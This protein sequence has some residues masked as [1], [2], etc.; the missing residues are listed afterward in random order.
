MDRI[1][2]AL[3][4]LDIASYKINYETRETAE[5]YFVKRNLDLT[6]ANTTTDIVVTVYNDFEKDGV[7]QRGAS[8]FFVFPDT[9]DEEI[10][11]S[12]AK[13]Y[14]QASYVSNPYFDM[15]QGNGVVI[16]TAGEIDLMDKAVAMAEALY[17]ADV[18][19][20]AYIN[21]AEIYAI[22]KNIRIVNS[23]GVD[24][25]FVQYSAEGEFVVQSKENNNDVELFKQFFYDDF[26]TEALAKKCEDSL[27]SVKD[28]AFAL[29]ADNKLP[30]YP[31]ILCDNTVGELLNFYV[32]KTNASLIHPGYSDYRPGKEV[33]PEAEGEKID[34]ELVP[35]RIVDSDGIELKN[36]TILKDGIVKNIHG[37]VQYSY[38][39]GEKCNGTFGKF[40]CNN[41]TVEAKDML[42]EPYIM[43]KSFSD[44]QMDPMDGYFGGEFRL[45]Y[46]FDGNATRILT[47]GTVSGN[48]YAAQ[49]NIVFSKER[50]EDA[51]YDIPRL[52][53][54]VMKQN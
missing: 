29:R 34:I 39:L 7:K 24:Y 5:L 47:G 27:K 50:Y 54:I 22:R 16:K 14:R 10:I 42:K 3:K 36:M 18:N 1:I 12:A 30:D 41:G 37:N 43:V 45:A 9:T 40:K 4:E 31:I 32:N 8:Q 11:E 25:S 13:A 28:R 46:I 49:N 35:D 26:D 38:Y 19:P 6:R 53:K 33:A 51:Q 17:S 23:E 2:K 48:M 21:S 20:K 15:A 44:F 52:A